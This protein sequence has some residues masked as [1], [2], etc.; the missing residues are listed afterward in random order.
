M[1]SPRPGRWLPPTLVGAFVVQ[2]AFLIAFYASDAY[3][4]A[5]SGEVWRLAATYATVAAIFGLL[6][7]P[8]PSRLARA[9]QVVV[10]GLVV[11]INFARFET[12]GAFDYAFF[13][14]NLR[15]LLTPLGR[16]IVGNQVRPI[17][18]VFLFVLPVA[19]GAW[20]TRLPSPRPKT[21]RRRLAAA[22][23]CVAIL[24]G[25]PLAGVRTHESLSS[26]VMSGVRFHAELRATESA[27]ASATYPYV[28]R[29]LPSAQARELGGSDAP[30]PHVILLFLESWS[31]IYT[32]RTRPDG[33][34]YTP[35]FDARRREG[36]TF[37]Y[38][39]GNSVQSSRGRFST[40]CSVIPMYRDKAVY[41]LADAP[42]RCLPRLLGEKGYQTM[43]ASGSDEPGFENSEPFFRHIGFASTHWESPEDRA[44][45]PRIW[46]AGLQDDAFYRKFFGLLD[47][48]IARDPK[49]PLFAVAINVSNH[50]PF[51]DNPAH[52]PATEFASK[53]R[54]NFVGSLSASDAWLA[55]FFEE[56]ERRPALRDALVVLVGDHS[57][58]ADEHGVHFNGLGA[59]E[60][61]FRT[62]FALR[63]PGHV[64]PR[65][66]T[67][68]AAS[69][70]D[71]APTIVDLLQI[72]H[73]SHFVGRSL[74]G[75][76][77]N[78][79]VPMVQPYDGLRLVAVRHPYKLERHEAAEQEHL[80]DLVSDPEEEHDLIGDP[81]RAP[82][83]DE[84]RRGIAQI[85][86]NESILRAKRVWPPLDREPHCQRAP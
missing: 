27:L 15:E 1:T 32:D 84:L 30:R 26:F 76:D 31:G 79:I 65:V 45:D 39:Y 46:G 25:L 9:A 6:L 38:F 57:F 3:D 72:R 73:R 81:A 34:R 41:A 75:D 86:T 36:L 55:T 51:R 19:A 11:A 50:Y 49:R 70:L 83:I 24:V 43:I 74:V 29:F 68:R 16:R 23:L 20:L 77:A 82:E 18:I 44:R 63:W 22:A 53:Y 42:L 52:A 2:T 12:T 61:S 64:P 13:H 8:A 17:E 71:V 7:V 10:F 37:D 5:R 33:T 47:E 21:P 58:P 62:A 67:D 80:Y 56:L 60:E 28:H 69:Q 66:V 48:E 78:A 40:L 85:R 35:V 54:R 4:A 14:Y 59:R